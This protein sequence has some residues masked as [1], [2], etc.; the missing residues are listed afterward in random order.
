[1]QKRRLKR[2]GKPERNKNSKSSKT[3]RR[4]LR[5][6]GKLRRRRRPNERKSLIRTNPLLRK[7]PTN[8]N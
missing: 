4:R 8:R 7:K 1:M 6:S 2:R 3:L 5:S